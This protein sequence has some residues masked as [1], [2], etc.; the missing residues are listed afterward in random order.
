M[1]RS[2]C[3]SCN[4]AVVTTNSLISGTSVPRTVRSLLPRCDAE[5]FP[6]DVP[7]LD[8]HA[9]PYLR[10]S[11]LSPFFSVFLIFAFLFY[12]LVILFSMAIDAVFSLPCLSGLYPMNGTSCIAYFFIE[13]PRSSSCL[14]I[15]FH[16]TLSFSMD[17]SYPLKSQIVL[18]SGI[19]FG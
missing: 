6:L 16:T 11:P 9:F 13:M 2:T 15:C 3:E 17:D 7:F 19:I 18:E 1:L 8:L 5:F 12:S 10:S 14:R 4:Y